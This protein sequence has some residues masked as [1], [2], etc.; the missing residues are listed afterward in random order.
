M[1]GGFL[2]EAAVPPQV[3]PFVLVWTQQ[4]GGP[5]IDADVPQ[6]REHKH[7]LIWRPYSDVTK[8][9]EWKN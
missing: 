4:W 1:E 3:E 6:S 5:S 9:S 7:C 2:T 8:E